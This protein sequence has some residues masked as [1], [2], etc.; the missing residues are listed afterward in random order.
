[1]LKFANPIIFDETYEINGK[2]WRKVIVE[3][4]KAQITSETPTEEPTKRTRPSDPYIFTP[5]KTK[6]RSGLELLDYIAKHTEYQKDFNPRLVN[7]DQP[8]RVM[9]NNFGSSTKKLISFLEA[10]NSGATCE[11][12]LFSVKA[13]PPEQLSKQYQMKVSNNFKKRKNYSKLPWTKP[14]KI[15]PKSVMEK[16]HHKSG[17]KPKRVIK[18]RHQKLSREDIGQLERHFVAN[19]TKPHHKQMER[20][21]K[22][23]NIDFNDVFTYFQNKW[24]GKLEYEHFKSQQDLDNE[25]NRRQLKKFEPDIVEDNSFYEEEAIIEQENAEED[26]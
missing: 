21:A 8:K 1:M 13:K 12:A 25:E 9:E 14:K 20:W 17:P 7:F 2:K 4:G 24:R 22:E 5:D 6:L 26:Y 10:I 16:W 3:R 11:D 18:K 19:V 15:G 23:M